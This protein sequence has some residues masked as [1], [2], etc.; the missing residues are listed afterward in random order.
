MVHSP[1]TDVGW[2]A[3]VDRLPAGL[4]LAASARQVGAFVRA[5]GVGSAECLL[6]LALI[7]GATPLSLRG[8]AA[9]AEATGLAQLSDVALLGRLQAADAW[10]SAVVA[11]LLSAAVAPPGGPRRRIRLIDATTIAGPGR[12]NQCWRLHA[13]Y[14]LAGDRFIG[15][16]LTDHHGSESLERFTPDPGDLAIGDRIYAKAR[17]LHHVTECGADFLVRRGLTGCR[18]TH[19]D[20]QPF[21]LKSALPDGEETRDLAVLVPP[22]TGSDRAPIPARL[23]IRPLPPEAAER[24]QRRARRKAAKHRQTVTAKRLTAAGYCMLL[25][26]LDG[27]RFSTDRVL[28]LYRLRWQIELA[29]KRLKSLVKLGDLQAKEP[30]LARS[31]LYAK[32]IFALLSEDLLRDI[33]DAFPPASRYPATVDLAAATHSSGHAG[34]P[35]HR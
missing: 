20:G 35:H 28:A 27:N 24:A 13:D 23:I 2:S 22:P 30:R 1:D 21:D 4:D 25:T 18:L 14:D 10:L 6:R 26:S 19:P 15:L 9:W 16:E 3:L 7:Y 32:I 11:A 12:L 31:C 5:R 17:Q 8:T 33:R 34:T 29:F